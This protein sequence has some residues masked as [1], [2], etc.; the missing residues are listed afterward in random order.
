[1]V[2]KE[3][4]QDTSLAKAESGEVSLTDEILVNPSYLEQLVTVRGNLSKG[5]KNHLEA[6]W[7]K[8]IDVFAWEL[9]NMTGG[10]GSRPEPGG[11]EGGRG[12]A[13]SRKIEFVVG[14]RYKCFLDA[15][16]GYHH[17]QM[18]KDDGE[19]TAFYMDQGNDEKM[20]IANIDETFDNLWRINM[21]LNLK[22]CSFGV[23]EGRFLGYMVTSKGI[24]ANPKKTKAII[25]MQSPP[26]DPEGNAEL[27]I[28]KENKDE[29]RWTEEAEKAFQKM[30][31]FIVELPLLTTP[32]KK[33]TLYVYQATATKAVSAVLLT[34]Q[35]GKQCLV[36]YVSRIL[37]EAER[38]YASLEKLALSLL[39]MSRRLR[40]YFEARPMK[41]THNIT[42]EPRNTIK[43]QVLADFLSEA[44]VGTQ[45]VVFF[46][47]T[48][49]TQVKDD[50]KNG[51]SS[52]TGHQIAR[53]LARA[54][55]EALL[56]GLL[57]AARMK[58]QV[59]NVVGPNFFEY[60]HYELPEDVV[61]IIFGIILELQHDDCLV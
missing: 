26:L 59:I 48:A 28:T 52:Q 15:Y 17:V 27:N 4:Y 5:C 43:G 16:N 58:V 23:E 2:E 30:K 37:N 47:V 53:D 33:E 22:K 10:F 29:Y 1:M 44:P 46:W 41:G 61:S 32:K 3:T 6:L 34:E 19:K 40:R 54:K 38:K 18:A 55:Y 51:L 42:Y 7:K 39:H 20:L 31:K 13:E 60:L 45:L 25:D 35:K 21:K 8:N 9:S 12:V 56:T 50:I 57:M 11:D 24:R 49:K 36:H 14:F